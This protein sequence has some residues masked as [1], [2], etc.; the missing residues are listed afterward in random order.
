[1]ISPLLHM[2]ETPRQRRHRRSPYE[3]A[4]PKCGAPA[5]A[6]CR[7]PSGQ[8]VLPHSARLKR[9]TRNG[10]PQMHDRPRLWRQMKHLAQQMDSEQ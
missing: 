4:C 1:M 2:M 3:V 6:P 10:R 9:V 5:L 7:F 8:A